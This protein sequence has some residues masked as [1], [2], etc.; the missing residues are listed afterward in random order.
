MDSN[1]VR[2]ELAQISCSVGG[3]APE[4]P[5]TAEQIAAAEK[6]WAKRSYSA[7]VMVDG[8]IENQCGGCRF[9]AATGM[10]YGICWNIKSRL[11]GC[12]TFEHGGCSEFDDRGLIGVE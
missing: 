5:P 4:Q 8:L 6:R 2:F 10:D 11:D 7:E 12:V 1:H 9:F 3:W